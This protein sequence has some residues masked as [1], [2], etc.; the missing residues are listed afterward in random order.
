[1]RM[2]VGPIPGVLA[3]EVPWTNTGW[4][5]IGPG[6]LTVFEVHA[7][8]NKHERKTIIPQGTMRFKKLGTIH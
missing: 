1:V 4:V 6:L 5:G 3:I 8:I 7:V 2:T